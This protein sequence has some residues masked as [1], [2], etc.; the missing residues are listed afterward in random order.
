MPDQVTIMIMFILCLFSDN[1]SD[2]KKPVWPLIPKNCGNFCHNIRFLDVTLSCFLSLV[3]CLKFS[4]C[5]IAAKIGKTL[6]SF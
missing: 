3:P 1:L 6:A 2:F 4:L 5:N